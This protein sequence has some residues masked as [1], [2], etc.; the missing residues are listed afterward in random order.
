[1]PLH[2]GDLRP[3]M[4]V[5]LQAYLGGGRGAPLD[6]AEREGVRRE[7]EVVSSIGLNPEANLLE[8]GLAELDE[9]GDVFRPGEPGRVHQGFDRCFLSG[10]QRGLQCPGRYASAGDAHAEDGEVI[11]GL[12]D[13]PEVV[14]L[15]RTTWD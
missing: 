13:D 2:L 3:D 7:G 6:R 10:L 8:S 9:N 14:L 5:E 15:G 4:S 12:V 11:L 1:L